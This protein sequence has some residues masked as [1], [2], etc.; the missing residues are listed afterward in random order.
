MRVLFVAFEFPPLGGGGVHRSMG[1]AKYLPAYGVQP[2]V[3][4]TDLPSFQQVMVNPIDQTLLDDLPADLVIERVSCLPK[5][6]PVS[7]KLAAWLRLFFS[8]VE[9]QAKWWRPHLVQ[10]LPA[11]LARHRPGLIYVSLPPMAMGPLWAKIARDYRLPLML[12]FRDAW[13][14]WQ[15]APYATWFHYRLALRLERQCLASATRVVCTS[16]QTRQDLMAVHPRIPGD[17]IVTITNGYD[18]E[19]TDWSL[20]VVD[21]S[22]RD[23]DSYVIGYLGSFYYSPAVRRAMFLPWWRKRLYHMPQYS[24]RK[25][26]WRYRSPFFFFRA[27]ERVIA[28]RPDLRH[29]LRIRFAGQKAD[30]LDEQIAKFHL[31]DLVE[32]V[33]YLNHEE[34]LAFQRECDSLL[35]TSAKVIGGDDYSIAGKTFEYFVARKPILGFV[36]KGA[37][38]D[39]LQQSGMALILDPDE[40]ETSARRLTELIDGEVVL[41][42]N[43]P[44][45]QNLHRREL[46]GRLADTMW[47]AR[48]GLVRG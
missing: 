2:I 29:R 43:A 26:D 46:T 11:V 23:S 31:E 20:Q 39:I 27:V 38:R 7:G 30:W 28:R 34:S 5:R 36:C 3:L 18:A 45:L 32:H 37:Q 1:F 16:A 47:Q 12:D 14:Q 19:V 25:E 17:K 22:S 13:T 42:P 24:S 21:S 35:I 48:A 9:P 4:T 40:T 44:Y 6:R 8:L 10:Q 41:T 15:M 33:G